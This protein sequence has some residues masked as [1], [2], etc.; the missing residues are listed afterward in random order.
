M[1]GPL[2]TG[3]VLPSVGVRPAS[4]ADH[5]CRDCSVDLCHD[6]RVLGLTEVLIRDIHSGGGLFRQLVHS[7]ARCFRCELDFRSRY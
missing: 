4:N 6:L 1:R 2:S 3:R 5:C 7:A